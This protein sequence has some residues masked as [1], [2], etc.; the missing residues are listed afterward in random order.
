MCIFLKFIHSFL[1]SFFFVNEQPSVHIYSIAHLLLRGVKCQ[2]VFIL[3]IFTSIALGKWERV[4]ECNF[5]IFL[6]RWEKNHKL[7]AFL[8]FP[9]CVFT[10]PSSL[11]EWLNVI[12]RMSSIR[13]KKYNVNTENIFLF[14]FIRNCECETRSLSTLTAREWANDTRNYFFSGRR[15]DE[16]EKRRKRDFVVFWHMTYKFLH[17]IKW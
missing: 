10:R 5:F 15:R 14:C 4:S 8:I 9:R 17:C 7:I 2:V 3:S 13:G 1:I 12:S 6:L 11:R 16:K